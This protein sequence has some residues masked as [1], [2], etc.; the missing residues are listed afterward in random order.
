MPLKP[1]LPPPSTPGGPSRRN[2]LK[3]EVKHPGYPATYSPLLRFDALDYHE[4][5]PKGVNYNLVY[6]ACGILVGNTWPDNQE[7]GQCHPKSYYYLTATTAPSADPVLCPDDGILPAGTYYL[8]VPDWND[9][10]PYP[11]TPSFNHWEF[12]HGRLP[13]P[14][15]SLS[16]PSM[17]D[18]KIPDLPKTARERTIFRDRCCR[19]TQAG[20]GTEQAHLV[21]VATSSWYTLNGMEKYNVDSSV[22]PQIDDLNNTLLLRSDVHNMLDH[23]ELTIVPKLDGGQYKL[24]TH[25]IRSQSRYAAEQE[26]LFHDRLIHQLYDVSPSCLFARFAWSLFHKETMRLFETRRASFQVRV[27]VMKPGQSPDVTTTTI[28]DLNELPS[29]TERKSTSKKRSV[30]QRG[31]QDGGDQDCDDEYWDVGQERIV[32]RDE[33]DFGLDPEVHNVSDDESDNGWG[34][35]RKRNRSVSPARSTPPLSRYVHDGIPKQAT[36]FRY[37]DERPEHA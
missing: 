34:R 15:R 10:K 6:Y 19:V 35:G 14:W 23:K 4:T 28:W 26:N 32:H 12:P 17:P 21:P 29:L 30:S 18:D 31:D 20:C 36:P 2:V 9:E 16:I 11:I 24:V 27:R 8:Y 1:H 3:V 5:G 25:L 22:F 13:L 7:E 33:E 37:D